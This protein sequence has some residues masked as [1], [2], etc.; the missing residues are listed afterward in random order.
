MSTRTHGPPS[1]TSL[2]PGV[3]PHVVRQGQYGIV[4]ATTVSSEEKVHL[5]VIP[6]GAT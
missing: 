1:P 2:K 5:P 3:W 6:P 4:G